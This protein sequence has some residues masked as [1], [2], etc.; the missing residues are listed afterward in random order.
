MITEKDKQF[1]IEL[2]KR[3]KQDTKNSITSVKH[4]LEYK[5]KTN[6]S[7]LVI[8]SDLDKIKELESHKQYVE[9]LINEILNN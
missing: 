8:K 5:K 3:E 1:I 4:F 6:M 2:L 9:N 7:E